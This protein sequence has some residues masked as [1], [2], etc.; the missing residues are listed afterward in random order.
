[1]F[2]DSC[3]QEVFATYEIFLSTMKRP[4]FIA[5]IEKLC[6]NTKKT[7][8]RVGYYKKLAGNPVKNSL[9]KSKLVLN[10]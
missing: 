9:K 3:F 2:S 5:K 8:G 6:A 4:S 7:L 1:L 10:P